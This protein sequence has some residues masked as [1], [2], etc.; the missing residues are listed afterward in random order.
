MKMSHTFHFIIGN[1]LP[2][3]YDAAIAIF[4]V[5]TQPGSKKYKF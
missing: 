1:K 2:T 5:A 4:S 3:C